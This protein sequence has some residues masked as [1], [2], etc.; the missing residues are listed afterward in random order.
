MKAQAQKGHL[1][2]KS[3]SWH[4]RWRELQRLPDGTILKRNRSQK[5]ANIRDYPRKS[6]V[7]GL[8]QEFMVKLNVTGFAPEATVMFD[9][10]VEQIYLPNVE[11]QKRPSTVRG[12]KQIWTNY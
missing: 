9:T 3:S 10:F 4:V 7:L 8:F 5:L 6:D 11:T 1:Y 2:K 12:Y